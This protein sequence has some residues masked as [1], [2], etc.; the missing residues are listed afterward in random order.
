MLGSLSRPDS[1]LWGAAGKHPV[2]RDY[3]SIGFISRGLREFSGLVEKAFI[4]TGSSARKYVSYR[5]FLKGR[6]KGMISCGILKDS[7]DAVG[8]EYPLVVAG[9]GAIAGWEERW[10]ALPAAMSAVCS[11]AEYISSRKFATLDEFKAGLTRLGVPSFVDGAGFDGKQDF[12]SYISDSGFIP[13]VSG[14][15]DRV[16]EQVSGY[17]ALLKKSDP[18]TPEAVF[19]GGTS[20][21]SCLCVFRK[22]LD[23]NNVLTLLSYA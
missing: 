14:D 9:Y 3:I 6:G 11:E 8:R 23:V 12:S 18:A 19:I 13:L 16:T 15:D 21:K 2:A 7:R 1:W 4:K 22:P 5:Y 17:M 10:E 20:D